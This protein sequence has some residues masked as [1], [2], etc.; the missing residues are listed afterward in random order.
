MNGRHISRGTVW[1]LRSTPIVSI[2]EF[3]MNAAIAQLLS[4]H[5]HSNSPL[6]IPHLLRFPKLYFVSSLS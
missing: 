5:A 4:L 1:F 2:S 6:S 3:I